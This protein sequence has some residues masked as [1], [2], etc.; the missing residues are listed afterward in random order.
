M[1]LLALV[2]RLVTTQVRGTKQAIQGRD[3]PLYFVIY[4]VL[5]ASPTVSSA[6]DTVDKAVD[7]PDQAF[8]QLR[9]W[10][11]GA[12]APA[13]SIIAIVLISFLLLRLLR[14]IV[15]RTIS[16]LIERG[17]QPTR[18]VTLKANTLTYVIESAGRL[19]VVVIAGMMVLSNLGFDIAPLIASAGVAGIAIGLG[20]Q[21]LIKDFINGFFILLE[22]QFSIGDV[23]SVNGNNGTVEQLSLRRTGLRTI[24]GAF[25]IIPNGDIRTVTNKTKGWSRAMIDVDVSYDDDVDH[26]MAVLRD[27]LDDFQEDPEFVPVITAPAEITGIEALGPYQVT[28]RVLVKTLPAEQWRV[29]RELRRRIKYTF[30][31]AGISM[32]YPH[33]VT[34]ARSDDATPA[35]ATAVKERVEQTGEPAGKR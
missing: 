35:P 16:R 21:S 34:I 32:P 31:R 29:Q 18:E 5:A 25:I 14:S 28:I 24:D 6:M 15:R 27:L 2:G 12:I 33:S 30:E 8:Q 11:S 7:N 26:V 4:S 1:A 9:D 23:I 22:D 20:A 10:A 17:D 19:I 13:I 3:C